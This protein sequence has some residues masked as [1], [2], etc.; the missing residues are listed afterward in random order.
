[1]GLRT[2][3]RESRSSSCARWAASVRLGAH[4]ALHGRVGGTLLHER[5]LLAL[6]PVEL[7]G[8]GRAT[9]RESRD[10]RGFAVGHGLLRGERATVRAGFR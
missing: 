8:R 7:L 4:G 6:R 10:A 5:L 9:I 1:M 2:V 3:A